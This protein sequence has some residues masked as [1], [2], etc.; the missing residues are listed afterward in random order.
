[1]PHNIS[2]DPFLPTHTRTF[3]LSHSTH[4]SRFRPVVHPNLPPVSFSYVKDPL[5][6]QSNNGRRRNHPQNHSGDKTD[7]VNSSLYAFSWADWVCVYSDVKGKGKAVE[8]KPIE[9]EDEEMEDDDDEDED[10]E[11]DEDDE[12]VSITTSP[13]KN[14]GD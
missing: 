10:M 4:A 3:P 5:I 6:N 14:K 1:M 8:E 12:D 9:H 13:S 11:G 7:H 2:A